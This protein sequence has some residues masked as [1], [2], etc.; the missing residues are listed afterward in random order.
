LFDEVKARWGKLDF[1]LHSIAFAPREDLQGRVVDCSAE[2]FALAMDVSCHSFLRMARLAEPLMQDGGCLDVRDLLRLGPG[3]GALQHDGAGQAALESATRYI[4]A[5]LGPKGIRAHAI[6]PGPIAARGQR[7]RPFRR[8]AGARRSR[9]SGRN[10]GFDRGCRRSGRFL[11][12]MLRGIL[13]APSFLLTP[14]SN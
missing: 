3:G 5:E 6:S 11:R 7:Y 1:L 12:A 4:A 8:I 14:D 10:V 2:G 13:P 9:S